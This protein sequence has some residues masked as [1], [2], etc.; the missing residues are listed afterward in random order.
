MRNKIEE[1]L[2]A[3]IPKTLVMSLLDAHLELK[4]QFY[5]EHFRPSELEGGRFVEAALRI[6]QELTSSAHIPIGK[7][8]PSFT[9]DYLKKI[10]NDANTGTH[11]SLRTHIPR[12]L[13]TVYAFRNQRDVGH[14]GGDVNPNEADA[15]LIVAV[16]D[17][18][19]AELIRLNFHCPVA[20]AQRIVDD[21][22]ERRI[23]II[24]NFDGFPKILR[25]N[26]SLPQ[27]IMT[28]AY[29]HGSKGF[30][31]SD[32][33]IWLKPASA[34]SIRTALTR[35]VQDRLFLHRQGDKCQIT[36]SG[37]E[38]VEEHIGFTVN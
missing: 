12:A 14:I 24:Q 33:I 25:K 19:L 28:I 38:Y 1:Q 16:C 37:L 4:E 2:S 30:E 11:A 23:P 27:Q 36:K 35:L 20:E 32:L 17:W 8:L 34:T 15:Y 22:V 9:E 31:V 3:N 18:V 21:L 5:Q 29:T 26:M 6:V 13:F 7:S 10:S